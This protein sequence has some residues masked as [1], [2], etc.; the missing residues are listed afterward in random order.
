MSRVIVIGA[1]VGGLAVAARL[2]VKGHDVLVLEQGQRPGGKLHTHRQDGFAFD[3]GP[4]LFTLPAVYR[5]L[6]LK[7][8]GALEE[9]T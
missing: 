6:F 1:G 9:A 7:T 2:A 8:G 5:D 4:S 3:T